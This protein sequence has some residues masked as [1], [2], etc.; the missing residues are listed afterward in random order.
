MV[1]TVYVFIL[2]NSK[3]SVFFLS[4]WSNDEC[5]DVVF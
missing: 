5:I 1:H 4:S 2:K 3:G